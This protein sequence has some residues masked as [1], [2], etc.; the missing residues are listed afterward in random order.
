MPP[1][2]TEDAIHDLE[3]RSPPQLV[4]RILGTLSAGLPLRL[5][6]D[7]NF[8][9]GRL[10]PR[11]VDGSASYFWL[12]HG[13]LQHGPGLG[14][15]LN[16]SGDGGFFQPV[17]PW[18]QWVLAPTYSALWALEDDLL[19]I[20]HLGLP[21]AFAADK[22]IGLELAIGGVYKLLAG[23]GLFAEL[24]VTTFGGAGGTLHPMLT[25]EL[26]LAID[27]EVLP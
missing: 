24:G 18:T 21:V 14:I 17:D 8:G 15:S 9:Q 12:S 7:R 22:S 6:R 1:F 13:R 26:G 10:G 2:A 19:G 27:H 3:L 23:L 25:A 4:P 20:A 5:R 16:L 11:F